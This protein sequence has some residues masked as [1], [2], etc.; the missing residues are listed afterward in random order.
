MQTVN[1]DMFSTRAYLCHP[2]RAVG[3]GRV[4][5]K[6][7]R[8]C[9]PRC[10]AHRT[11]SSTS[12]SPVQA[13][14]AGRS[15]SPRLTSSS[16]CPSVQ[17]LKHNTGENVWFR[18][19]CLPTCVLQL[20]VCECVSPPGSPPPNKQIV[21]LLRTLNFKITIFFNF[22]LVVCLSKRMSECE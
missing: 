6:T 14:R 18:C 16:W 15:W 11:L 5:R 10:P 8:R 22:M 13:S 17:V 9:P 21:W 3:R 12:S 4:C 7:G 19:N 20:K 1:S 2:R